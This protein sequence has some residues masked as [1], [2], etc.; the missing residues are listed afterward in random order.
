MKFINYFYWSLTIG[1]G[2]GI[3]MAV[4]RIIDHIGHYLRIRI[5]FKEMRSIIKDEEQFQQIVQRLQD[6]GEEDFL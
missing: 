3:A 4:N 2:F 6:E 5:T 1:F